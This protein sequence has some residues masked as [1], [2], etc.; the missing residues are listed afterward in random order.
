MAA[1]LGAEALAWAVEQAAGA[2]VVAMAAAPV[3]E[4]VARAVAQVVALGA[5]VEVVAMAAARGV[6]T[7]AQAGAEM[8]VVAMAALHGQ[9]AAIVLAFFAVQFLKIKRCTEHNDAMKHTPDV[10][11]SHCP[12]FTFAAPIGNSFPKENA[13]FKV[14]DLTASLSV[15]KLCVVSCA[16]S[17]NQADDILKSYVLPLWQKAS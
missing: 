10:N 9:R 16:V 3:V 17:K 1:A 11:M 15:R 8:V 6:E 13:R 12:A 2:E 5:G 7:V 14:A 4:A